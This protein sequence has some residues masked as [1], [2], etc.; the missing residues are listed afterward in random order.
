MQVSVEQLEG[1]ERRV[2]VQVP[3]ETVDQE[4]RQR[5]QSMARRVKV[6]GFRPGKVPVKLVKRMY[7]AQVR[8]E[9]LGDLMQSSFRD[10][11]EQEQLSPVSSP[12]VQP[13]SVDEGADFE[14][15][16]TFEVRPEFEPVGIAGQSIK[17][18]VVEVT[19]AD[20]DNM[21]ETLRK[22]RA[23]WHPVERPAEDG[24]KITLS[25]A[26]TVD[27]ETFPGG[28]G[29]NVEIVLGSKSMLPALEREL[30]S[31]QAGTEFE[32]DMPFP[33][34]HLA[35]ELAGKTA[36][37]KAEIHQVAE[38]VLPD[39]D[40]AFV[41]SFGI[42]S[43]D[44]NDLRGELR[45]NMQ[46]ELQEAIQSKVKNQVVDALLAV[47]DIPVPKAMIE[48]NVR[49]FAIQ[50][51]LIR[52]DDDP[53]EQQH[54]GHHKLFETRARRQAALGFAIFKIAE[55]NNIQVDPHR[56]QQRI[57]TIAASYEESAQ[58]VQFYNSDPKLL[59]GINALVLEDQV[60]DSLL[61]EAQVEEQPMSFDELMRPAQPTSPVPQEVSV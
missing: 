45:N 30:L 6:D 7:G 34:D 28:S 58:V 55:R 29:E 15:Q 5:L 59:E 31:R 1:L 43:G 19:E 23:E 9:V 32:F 14:Y 61:N 48:R 54:Q 35:E 2:T 11:L 22:Q 17:R 26:A 4:V 3:A 13:V 49:H 56:V 57:E 44:I 46:R 47:N 20:V 25:F 16:A 39:V 24:D 60:I 33:E 50:A 8:Q 21:V 53:D 42:T 38:P 40:E 41:K 12:D 52:E 36:H 18:P 27:G 51:G 10:A 37:F